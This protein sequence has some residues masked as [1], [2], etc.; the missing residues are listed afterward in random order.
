M[1]SKVLPVE[2]QLMRARISNRAMVTIQLIGWA[3]IMIVMGMFLTV[4]GK[5]ITECLANPR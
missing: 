5:S 2:R 1:V 3:A 4:I